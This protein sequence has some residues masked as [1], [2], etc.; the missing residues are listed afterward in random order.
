ML[1]GCGVRRGE[2]LALR[3]DEIQLGEEHW[4]VADLLGEAGHKVRGAGTPQADIGPD[5]RKHGCYRQ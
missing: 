3:V 5:Y 1:I 2:L 4:A